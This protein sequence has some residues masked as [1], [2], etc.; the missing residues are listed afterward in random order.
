MYLQVIKSFNNNFADGLRKISQD[1]LRK[2]HKV[3]ISAIM[4]N[5]L[6]LKLDNADD[7]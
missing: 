2:K 7:F 4:K 6:S 5:S 3:L 1:L